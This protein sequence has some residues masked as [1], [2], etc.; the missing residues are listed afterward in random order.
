MKWYIPF[1]AI[2]NQSYRISI[3]TT[4]I[5]NEQIAITYFGL[6]DVELMRTYIHRMKNNCR[7]YEKK[8]NSTCRFKY[9]AH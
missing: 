1:K 9:A 4:P 8:F 5:E 3:P 6:W 2:K 7:H